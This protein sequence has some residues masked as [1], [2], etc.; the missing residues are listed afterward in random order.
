LVPAIIVVTASDFATATSALPELTSE[1][2]LLFTLLAPCEEVRVFGGIVFVSVPTAFVVTSTPSSQVAPELIE[3]PLMPKLPEPG[4]ALIVAVQVPL[5]AVKAA[6]AG[7]L[8]TSPAGMVSVRATPV[9]AMPIVEGLLM[10]I[11][12]RDVPPGISEVGLKVLLTET[13]STT[14]MVLVAADVLAML[15][16]ALLAVTLPIGIVFV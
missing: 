13:P 8:T 10:K 11:V 6:L 14:L 5:V 7:D 4:V 2:E 16:A 1:A 9:N 3:P 15:P 12:I